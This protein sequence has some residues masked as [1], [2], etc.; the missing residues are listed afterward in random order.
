MGVVCWTVLVVEGRATNDQLFHHF[1][2][3]AQI[4][5]F[6]LGAMTIVELIDTHDGFELITSR[7]T[8]TS[9]RKLLSC[10]ASGPCG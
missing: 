3:I 4:L 1:G 5:F 10:S 2:G 7:I 8:T 6:L 9:R